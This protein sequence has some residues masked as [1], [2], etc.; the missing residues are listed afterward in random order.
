MRFISGNRVTSRYSKKVALLIINATNEVPMSSLE[1]KK[2]K[3]EG[4]KNSFDAE[5]WE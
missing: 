3:K 2:L 4:W 5:T 1:V